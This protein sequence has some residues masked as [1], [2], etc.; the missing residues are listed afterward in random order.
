MMT[1]TT[2]PSWPSIECFLAG[3]CPPHE[4]ARI[5]A[6]L[7]A[8]PMA[9]ALIDSHRDAVRPPPATEDAELVIDAVRATV[10][11]SHGARS[12]RAWPN[13][14]RHQSAEG[15]GMAHR[16]P[17]LG[18]HSLRR[19]GFLGRQP[20]RSETGTLPRWVTHTFTVAGA[21]LLAVIGFPLWTY[22]NI[23]R[24]ARSFVQTYTT[25]PGQHASVMLADGSRAQLGPATTLM[26][27]T[28]ADDVGARV[29]GQVLFTVSHR[30][31][32]LFRVHVGQAMA[33]VLGTQFLARRYSTDAVA[34]VVVMD[35]RVS[36]SNA[37]TS[38]TV[39]RTHILTASMMG[40]VSDSGQIQITRYISAEEY[41]RVGT[42]QLVFRNT[43]LRTAMLELGRAYG[44]EIRVAD[45]AL[46]TQTLNAIIPLHVQSL[47]RVLAPIVD[48]LDAH[49]V[50]VGTTI[51][52]VPGRSGT[53][54]PA[55]SSP[56][57]LSERQY[58]R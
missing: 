8:N 47:T 48:A 41:A 53:Q 1:D 54:R 23:H 17:L 12:V 9:A 52:L 26:V 57:L 18:S 21:I 42:G 19:R 31:R 14:P 7:A 37:G 28:D 24:T 44:V 43:P 10:V 46:A 36:L 30:E 4:A 33:E 25:L 2:H 45:S 49:P 11:L 50:R 58:G 34:R 32:R 40:T 51:T 55:D 39:R 3:E 56:P 13:S 6:F 22:S 29:D 20:L 16:A 38:A 5:R 15:R 27:T 35:G